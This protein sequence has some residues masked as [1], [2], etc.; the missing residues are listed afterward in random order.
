M[1]NEPSM[2]GA[3][4]L[5][6]TDSGSYRWTLSDNLGWRDVRRVYVRCVFSNRDPADAF[7]DIILDQAAP[8]LAAATL[9]GRSLRTSASDNRA[10]VAMRL[11]SSRSGRAVALRYTRKLRLPRRYPKLWVKLVDGA[12]NTSPWRKLTARRR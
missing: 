9:T 5:P 2:A 1:S 11:K 12:G 6:A 7:D 3:T 4:S 8:E 10:L